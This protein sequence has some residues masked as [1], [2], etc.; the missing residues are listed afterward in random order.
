MLVDPS[1]KVSAPKV[2]DEHVIK[3]VDILVNTN[4]LSFIYIYTAI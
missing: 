3:W 1:T 2:F 4:K